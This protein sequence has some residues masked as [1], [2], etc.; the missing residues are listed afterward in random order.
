MKDKQTY[1]I[2]LAGGSGTRLWPLSRKSHPKQFFPL[3]PG[4]PLLLEQIVSSLARITVRENI[5]LA[6]GVCYSGL[7][8]S[9]AKSL[10][11]PRQN[12]FFEPEAKNSFAP[13][14]LIA[15]RINSIDPGGVMVVVPCD[16]LISSRIGFTKT[17]KTAIAT[18]KRGY[19]VTIGTRPTRPETGYGYIKIRRQKTEDRRQRCYTVERF[20]EKPGARQAEK[21]IREKRYFW[22]AGMFI[23]QPEIFLREASKFQPAAFK[24]ISALGEISERENNFK[25]LWHRLPWISVDYAVME[26]SKKIALVPADFTWVDSGNWEAIYQILKKAKGGNVLKGQVVSLGCRDS[27][28]F[29]QRRLVGAVGLEEMVVVDTPDA[30]LV[31]PRA[32]SQ[33]VKA[34]VEALEKKGLG[35]LL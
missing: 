30:L 8:K 34:L 25:G 31:C 2:I 11:I 10:G 28:I 32:K 26:K 24:I 3:C 19:I 22:N 14:T 23:F 18:A 29:S 21:F 9:H 35:K 33:A 12:Y 27:I 13:I 5:Y 15:K 6:T 17:V 16:N 4:R 7:V 1:A 20:I